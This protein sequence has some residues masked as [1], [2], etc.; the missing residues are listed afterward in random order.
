MEELNESRQVGDFLLRSKYTK[1]I[2]IE[3]NFDLKLSIRMV[4]LGAPK[5][6]FRSSKRFSILVL[7]AKIMV[8][9]YFS[10]SKCCSAD[11]VNL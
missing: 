11:G 10:H 3:K 1:S 7:S 8:K 5:F 4:F 2:T 6:Q 9:L